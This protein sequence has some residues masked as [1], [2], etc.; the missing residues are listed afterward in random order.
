MNRD[1]LNSSHLN[2]NN[3]NKTTKNTTK[4]EGD[5]VLCPEEVP[6]SPSQLPPT[7]QSLRV[8]SQTKLPA[9]PTNQPFYFINLALLGFLFVL[10]DFPP[11]LPRR[12]LYVPTIFLLDLTRGNRI[13]SSGCGRGMYTLGNQFSLL[14]EAVGKGWKDQRVRTLVG[15]AVGLH[16][17]CEVSPR[18]YGKGWLSDDA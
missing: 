9:S 5:P 11:P 16:H 6:S 14:A 15:E 7:P 8:F 13:L 18:E 4:H 3:N 10:L 17:I 1:N 12:C 2:N